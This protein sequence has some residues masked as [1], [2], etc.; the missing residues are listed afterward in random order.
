MVSAGN[1]V[2]IDVVA[3]TKKATEGFKTVKTQTEG[4]KKSGSGLSGVMMGLGKSMALTAFGALSI[5]MVFKEGLKAGDAFTHSVSAA[6]F[7]L[8]GMGE[9]GIAAFDKMS[10]SFGD[11][12]DEVHTTQAKVATAM[13]ILMSTTNDA[14]IS[15][16]N[17]A[18]VFRI[19]QVKG[20]DFEQVARAM[21]QALY[22]DIIPINDLVRGTGQL[23]SGFANLEQIVHMARE[24]FEASRTTTDKVS[25]NFAQMMEDVGHFIFLVDTG[26][27]T[28]FK[29]IDALSKF[30]DQQF[31]AALTATA[32]FFVEAGKAAFFFAENIASAAFTTAMSFI[33]NVIEAGLALEGFITFVKDAWNAV[34]DFVV[35][36]AKDI[37]GTA[38]L[39]L[40]F[41][42]NS[43]ASFISIFFNIATG[44]PLSPE[45]QAKINFLQGSIAGIISWFFNTQTGKAIERAANA[46]INFGFSVGAFIAKFF[47][48]WSGEAKARVISATIAFAKFLPDWLT[49]WTDPAGNFIRQNISLAFDFAIDKGEWLW[50][51]INGWIDVPRTISIG[52]RLTPIGM[53]W[54]AV[55]KLLN[56]GGFGGS[57]GGGASIGAGGGGP[58][59]D[60]GFAHGGV[61][62]GGPTIVGERGPELV[63]LPSGSYVKP[64]LT[65]VGGGGG[66]TVNINESFILDESTL[67]RLVRMIRNELDVQ[68]R[69]EAVTL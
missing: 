5:G 42:I 11:I 19:A 4:L 8:V 60:M 14:S 51:K 68:L 58:E 31:I 40:D 65:G 47:E 38:K 52:F 55:N 23:V 30:L 54:D 15:A 29:P 3:D 25:D 39:A 45:S 26:F 50:N 41:V 66:V 33:K 9:V 61:S 32:E 37:Q 67:N 2:R 56:L 10:A 12:A 63:N 17:L 21:G 7:S 57:T 48:T 16:T 35:Q 28:M 62:G 69:G 36:M 24:E 1:V 44:R 6:R 53:G 20:L 64:S 46:T 49:K 34:K 59:Y 13:G 18:D 22:G 27:R 43:V